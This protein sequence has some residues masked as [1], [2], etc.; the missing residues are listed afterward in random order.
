MVPGAVPWATPSTAGR[1][2]AGHTVVSADGG[3]VLGGSDAW[4]SRRA[5]L[6]VE[7]DRLRAVAEMG[8]REGPLGGPSEKGPLGGPLEKGPLGGPWSAAGAFFRGGLYCTWLT[9][10]QF[11]GGACQNKQDLLVGMPRAGPLLAAR[12]QTTKSPS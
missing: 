12:A 4:R 6:V 9:A 11:G 8:P 1:G 3:A 10:L 2:A 5:K 7:L